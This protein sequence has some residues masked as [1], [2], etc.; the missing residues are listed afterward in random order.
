MGRKRRWKHGVS[1]CNQFLAVIRSI[2]NQRFKQADRYTRLNED[3]AAS[4]RKSLSALD[5][6]T[7]VA[8][9]K[10]ELR[11]D[12]I[13]LN[14]L[15]SMREEMRPRQARQSL[16]INSKVYWA[17]RKRIRR[18]AENLPGARCPAARERNK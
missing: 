6:Q 10:E 12:A 16:G 2:G 4:P 7:I 13:A 11:G 5:A 14:I 3:V 17:A 18:R 9:L 1:R 15:E 8:R